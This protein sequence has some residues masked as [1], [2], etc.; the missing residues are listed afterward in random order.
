MCFGALPEGAGNVKI[1]RSEGSSV[2]VAVKPDRGFVQPMGGQENLSFS[3]ANRV[4]V[5][6]PT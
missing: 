6:E 5:N 3:D 2:P 4:L 1:V